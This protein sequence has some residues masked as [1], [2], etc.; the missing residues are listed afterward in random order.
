VDGGSGIIG[1]GTDAGCCAAAMEIPREKMTVEKRMA[2][3]DT[4]LETIQP[5]QSNFSG[6]Q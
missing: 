2:K 5:L 6:S 1:A 4:E 3:W